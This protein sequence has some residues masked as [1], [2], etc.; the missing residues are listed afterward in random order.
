MLARAISNFS[1][2]KIWQGTIN[3]VTQECVV[4]G[5]QIPIAV[6]NLGVILVFNE[7]CYGVVSIRH[8]SLSS[9]VLPYA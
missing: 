1:T 5:S 2:D 6:A 8:G 7:L 9:L 3:F 4:F